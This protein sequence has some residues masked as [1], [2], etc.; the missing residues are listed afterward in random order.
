MAFVIPKKKAGETEDLKMTESKSLENR[1]QSAASES[2]ATPDKKKTPKRKQNKE[3]DSN[4]PKRPP[5]YCRLCFAPFL[6]FSVP[7]LRW[8]YSVKLSTQ[9]GTGTRLLFNPKLIGVAD[10]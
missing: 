1:V 10:K 3:K 4:A 6:T 5:R 7:P 8:I 9:V 2:A